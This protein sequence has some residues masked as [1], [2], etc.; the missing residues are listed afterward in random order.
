MLFR[1]RRG[2][3]AGRSAVGHELT[4]KKIYIPPMASGSARAFAAGF[5]ALGV[6]ANV[7]APSDARTRELG[8]RFTSGD[9]CYPAKVTVGD[10]MKVLERP[11]VDPARTAFF[12][13]TAD[14]PCRFGQ[15]AYYLRH[16]LDANGYQQVEVLSPTSR[17]AYA[18]LG[19]LARPFVRTAWRMLVAADA[20][21]KLLLRHRPYE[22]KSGTSDA[23]HEE[24][25]VDICA[26]VERSSTATWPQLRALRGAL[27]RCR[28][29]FAALTTRK[30]ESRPLIGVVGEIF[31]RLNTF[32]N[33]DAV[34]RLEEAGAEVWLSGISEWVSYTVI[35]QYR[36]LRLHGQR[37]SLKTV[38]TWMRERVQHRDE[39]RLL[40]PF[41][42]DFRGCEEPGVEEMIECARPY[43]PADG[44]LGEMV[45]NVGRTICLAGK[46]VDGIIDISPFTCM[47]GI[48]CEAIYP[49][50]SRDLGGLP[51]RALHF[52]GTRQDLDADLAVYLDMARSYQRRKT[53]RRA[54]STQ[55]G[56]AS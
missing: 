17:N 27:R 43:L 9:E 25:L 37:Y 39:R 28:R 35:E 18:G 36:K 12:L 8:A 10:F 23:V 22:R 11:D 34:R 4:G 20:L 50:V 19:H 53:A 49:R 15:Y 6:D 40:E 3:A 5:R 1:R 26:T 47:N 7:T 48:V 13:P 2:E 16:V 41:R 14:G 29:R 38:A 51:I 42:H 44:S 45:L 31:C 21:Q 32:S 52:D 24:C 46:D 33:D 56:R 55:I 30:D 54:L